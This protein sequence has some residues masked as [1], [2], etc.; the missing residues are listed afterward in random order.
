M[1]SFKYA[2]LHRT[3]DTLRISP[4]NI[5]LNMLDVYVTTQITRS[6]ASTSCGFACYGRLFFLP[7]FS[8][9]S[10]QK[11]SK[12][13]DRLSEKRVPDPDPK[14]HQQKQDAADSHED[15]RLPCAHSVIRLRQFAGEQQPDRNP[16]SHEEQQHNQAYQC[17]DAHDVNPP[18]TLNS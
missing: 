5:T 16:A 12:P 14:V 18:Q 17:S 7:F 3:S 11:L 6:V 1:L 13:V 9:T 10:F 8:R 2:T 15:K 4:F